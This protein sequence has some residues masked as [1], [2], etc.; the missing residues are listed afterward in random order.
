MIRHNLYFYSR[1]Y[2]VSLHKVFLILN[3]A[4][5]FCYSIYEALI[6]FSLFKLYVLEHTLKYYIIYLAKWTAASF[7]FSQ[8]T[9]SEREEL[10]FLYGS[11]V[12]TTDGQIESDILVIVETVAEGTATG[13]LH[14]TY[15]R[16]NIYYYSYRVVYIYNMFFKLKCHITRIHFY[17]TVIICVTIHLH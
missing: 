6:P 12:L 3:T 1:A 10:G 8:P 16:Y 5:L 9:F 7:S 13:N 2:H 11:V 14:L 15:S 17:N 4:F